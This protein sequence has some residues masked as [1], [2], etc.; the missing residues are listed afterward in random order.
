[1]TYKLNLCSQEFVPHTKKRN[2]QTSKSLITL[3]EGESKMSE[4][5]VATSE[6]TKQWSAEAPIYP[7]SHDNSATA[8][9]TL[10]VC[11]DGKHPVKVPID[12]RPT[13]PVLFIPG[14]MGSN[15][16]N[17]KYNKEIAL[18]KD[19]PVWNFSGGKEAIQAAV[20]D[21][22]IQLKL[23]TISYEDFKKLCQ[24]NNEELKR[25][26]IRETADE[27][28]DLYS[29]KDIERIL[30]EQLTDHLTQWGTEF[31][32]SA[33]DIMVFMFASTAVTVGAVPTVIVGG[34]YITYIWLDGGLHIA[35]GMEPVTTAAAKTAANSIM[36]EV[37]NT[38]NKTGGIYSTMVGYTASTSKMKQ[39][40]LDQFACKLYDEKLT[41]NLEKK[42]AF[43][44]GTIFTGYHEFLFNL[45]DKLNN[46]FHHDSMCT[47]WAPY[48][49][50]SIDDIR[51]D[52]L[53]KIVNNEAEAYFLLNP[54]TQR[55]RRSRKEIKTE[56]LKQTAAFRFDIWA[57]GY[58]WLKSNADSANDIATF[59]QNKMLPYYN[60]SAGAVNLA[61]KKFQV[62]LITHGSG[63]LIAKH[64]SIENN[65]F[66]LGALHLSM[67]IHGLP[68]IYK[69]ARTGIEENIKA[70]ALLSNMNI[71]LQEKMKGIVSTENKETQVTQ[72]NAKALEQGSKQGV[73]LAAI[74]KAPWAPNLLYSYNI[75]KIISNTP[76]VVRVANESY[77]LATGLI[78]AARNP[79]DVIFGTSTESFCSVMLQCQ[80]VLE[81]LPNGTGG[82]LGTTAELRF[83]KSLITRG[84]DY[85][86][87]SREGVYP[88]ESTPKAWLWQQFQGISTDTPFKA[89]ASSNEEVYEKIYKGKAWYSLLPEDNLDYFDPAGTVMENANN[90][91]DE[92]K[93]LRKRVNIMGDIEKGNKNGNTYLLCNN[94]QTLA[95]EK[96]K[97]EEIKEAST[98]ATPPPDTKAK[99]AFVGPRTSE[100]KNKIKRE[101]FNCFIDKVK[102]FHLEIKSTSNKV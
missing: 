28:M 91:R 80:G 45:D 72:Q 56:D 8:E 63:G 3:H 71:K 81:L 15:L 4:K 22:Y 32:K 33:V 66:I 83:K 13:I 41:G 21:L 89:L 90:I 26:E 31:I 55:S 98:K 16:I 82:Y 6:D 73:Q 7:N 36:P 19:T 78:Y 60:E 68:E 61:T 100:E 9:C 50:D 76:E 97:E 77:D 54:R 2:I 11:K 79:F 27:M 29:D 88:P 48:L 42:Q 49:G 87:P 96:Q 52:A 25:K 74:A 1:M 75:A 94:D 86:D 12:Q 59:I 67:P 30:K 102:A 99:Q 43:G 18:P 35:N 37:I 62:L 70:I 85:F 84:A 46:I 58:N 40:K 93:K 101:L 95:Q 5:E 69:R 20:E 44:W 39:R 34:V 92:A 38:T 65:R 23:N 47:N 10:T 64:I 57:Q 24:D 14:L 51:L 17:E 53:T